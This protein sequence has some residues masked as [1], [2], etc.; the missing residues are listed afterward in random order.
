MKNLFNFFFSFDKLMKEGLVRAFFWLA[1]IN[2]ALR[3][4]AQTLDA[5]KLDWFAAVF[6]L[7]EFFVGFL[8]AVVVLR[9]IAELAIA[10]FRIN[11]NLSPDGGKSETADID[12]VAEAR[13]AAEQAAKRA[14]DMTKTAVDKTSAATKS[15]S[16]KARSAAHDV[17]D[18]V[19]DAAHDVGDKAKAVVKPATK[20]KTVQTRTTPASANDRTIAPEVTLEPKAAPKRR[21]RP[22]GSTNKPKTAAAKKPATKPATKK[23]PAKKP[24]S[25]RSALKKDGTPRKKPG[26]KPKS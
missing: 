1:L 7:F 14:Q 11:D 13:R 9:L 20:T 25:K 4:F 6:E 10:L 15:A 3:F 26:P 16:D 24:A 5:I 12:P 22:K 18:K 2:L 19:S 23:A 17:G 21:G 8:L